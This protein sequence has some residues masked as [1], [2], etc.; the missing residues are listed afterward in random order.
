VYPQ[1][2]TTKSKTYH[3]EEDIYFT[4]LQEQGNHSS[5]ALAGHFG[6]PLCVI[7]LSM[8]GMN[9]TVL[10]KLFNDLPKRRMVLLE[11]IDSIGIKTR[12]ELKKIA[13][14]PKMGEREH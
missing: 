6:V 1:N 4:V 14:C 13:A 11:D 2:N 3:I 12:D 9:D 7:E 8:E 5:R 10:Y